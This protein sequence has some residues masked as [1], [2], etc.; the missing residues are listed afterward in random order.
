ML[1]HCQVKRFLCWV[2]YGV[3]MAYW[4]SIAGNSISNAIGLTASMS[5]GPSTSLHGDS[6][7]AC[8]VGFTGLYPLFF[9]PY[10]ER[11]LVDSL[12]GYISVVLFPLLMFFCL[13]NFVVAAMMDTF[14]VVQSESLEP[15]ANMEQA[16]KEMRVRLCFLHCSTVCPATSATWHCAR[17]SSTY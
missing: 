7:V 14:S 16:I 5:Y 4:K 11:E 8:A 6:T 3:C 9:D 1:S 10:V 17:L 12:T 2:Q 15:V 13:F